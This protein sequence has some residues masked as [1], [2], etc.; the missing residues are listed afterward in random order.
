MKQ[1]STSKSSGSLSLCEKVS[2]TFRRIVPYL[3]MSHRVLEH[4]TP[5][6]A[7]K[8][9]ADFE[10]VKAG[11]INGTLATKILVN[12]VRDIVTFLNPNV[13]SHS[14]SFKRLIYQCAAEGIQYLALSSNWVSIFL[15]DGFF[16]TAVD[17]LMEAGNLKGLFVVRQETIRAGENNFQLVSSNTLADWLYKDSIEEE[18]E[19]AGERRG[20]EW[21]GHLEIVRLEAIPPA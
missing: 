4:S 8:K 16:M 5:E 13:G 1:P 6:I 20:W 18:L 9:Y 12:P 14:A 11:D 17:N 10:T 2:P 15:E 3:A 7:Y 19:E 21:D